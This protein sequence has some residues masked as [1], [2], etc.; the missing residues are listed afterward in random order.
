MGEPATAGLLPTA[1]KRVEAQYMMAYGNAD[2]NDGYSGG[3]GG[4]FSRFEYA[5]ESSVITLG[6]WRTRVLQLRQQHDPGLFSQQQQNPRS[7]RPLFRGLW[8]L[9]AGSR[10][11]AKLS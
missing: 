4:E 6:F 11:D 7:R 10:H 2:F 8:N 3:G 5:C 1:A 9:L